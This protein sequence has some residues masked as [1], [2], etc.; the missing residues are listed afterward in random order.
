MADGITPVLVS[1]KDIDDSNW[2]NS[3]SSI[4]YGVQMGAC[5][6]MFFVVAVLTKEHKR[7]TAIFILNI[8][9]L[10]FGFLRALLFALYFVSPWTLLYPTFGGD[11]TGFPRSAYATSIVGSVMPLL[12]TI[13]V[14]LSLVL[15]AHTVCH[16]TS[17]SLRHTITGLSCLV[18]LLAVGFRF[19]VTVTNAL[20]IMSLNSYY[21]KEWITTGALVTETISIWFFSL[22]FTGK[23][24]Y[25]L[26]TRH[27][28]GWKQWS[29]V[30]I[31]AAMGGCTMVIPCKCF[32]IRSCNLIE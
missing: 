21:S 26:Y 3:A 13:T 19:A 12:M 9:S 29:G 5:L 24:A 30:R 10:L 27:R 8:L 18:L 4:N 25:T 16:S 7:Q 15:Q 14:D 20:A 22:I 23:L 6:V 31:L 32:S 2:Y 17:N 11:Y 28:N 1:L